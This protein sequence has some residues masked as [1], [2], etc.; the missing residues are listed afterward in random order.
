VPVSLIR[1][2]DGE[3]V[4]P[5]NLAGG[6]EALVRR[7]RIRLALVLI[8]TGL[9]LAYLLTGAFLLYLLLAVESA[10]GLVPAVLILV[11]A[12]LVSVVAAVVVSI[13]LHVLGA[14][15]VSRGIRNAA[16]SPFLETAPDNASA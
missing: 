15:F 12:L 10:Y 4:V 13:P 14:I 9:G 5:A 7:T 3:F 11:P 1:R 16:A 8:G 6:K 2:P